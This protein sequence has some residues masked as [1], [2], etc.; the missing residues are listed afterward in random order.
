[1]HAVLECMVHDQ[2]SGGGGASQLAAALSSHLACVGGVALSDPA[3]AVSA[4][5]SAAGLIRG[6]GLIMSAL[7]PA[8]YA[9]VA[10]QRGV[11]PLLADVDPRS[12]GLRVDVVQAL[13]ARGGQAIL[14]SHPAGGRDDPALIGA[15]DVPV[16]EVMDG[17]WNDANDESVALG[18]LVL[19]PL[20]D[21]G[22]I[23][24]GGGMVVLARS[25]RR[26][27]SIAAAAHGQPASELPNLNAALALAQLPDAASFVALRAKQAELFCAA[28][29]ANRHT[30]FAGVAAAAPMAF[31]VLV[32]SGLKHVRQYASKHGVQTEPAYRS[33]ALDCYTADDEEAADGAADEAT[34][35]EPGQ[36]GQEG[37]DP[38]AVTSQS[39]RG[40]DMP[41]LPEVLRRQLQE[42]TG[43]E[44]AK[45]W[46]AARALSRQCLLFPLYPSLPEE[47]VHRIAKV[48]ATL[49]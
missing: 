12:G 47:A 20:H 28:L 37:L 2:L 14:L 36:L 7:A 49:P 23:T 40:D 9:Q 3:A 33:A 44:L 11:V 30:T 26:E 38:V 39:L 22:L 25:R 27:R 34:P 29:L 18:D 46:P 19:V 8:L 5:Y 17:R 24:A 16:I 32:E 42:E 31:P 45:D 4:A 48:L 1:M 41:K 13:L 35:A 21:R 15:A 10:Q 6:S 43:K